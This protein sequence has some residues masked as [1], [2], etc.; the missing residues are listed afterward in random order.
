MRRSCVWDGM[1]F[2]MTDKDG[3]LIWNLGGSSNGI[4]SILSGGGDYTTVYYKS[5]SGRNPAVSEFNNVTKD[6]CTEYYQYNGKWASANGERQFVDGE[7][8]KSGI[9]HTIRTN[10]PGA[11]LIP[12]GYYVKP[13]NG[14]FLTEVSNVEVGDSTGQKKTVYIYHFVSGKITETLS[15][16]FY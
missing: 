1:V 11:Y 14:I 10:V 6:D 4:G 16:E 3:R 7:E 12:D 2:Q 8:A 15:K 9:V 13:N 5:M